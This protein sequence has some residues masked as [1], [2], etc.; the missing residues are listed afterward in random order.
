[1]PRNRASGEIIRHNIYNEKTTADDGPL[2]EVRRA[3]SGRCL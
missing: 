2:T 3:H 1:M